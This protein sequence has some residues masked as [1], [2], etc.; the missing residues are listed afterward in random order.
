MRRWKPIPG[1]EGLYEVSNMGEVRSCNRI[2]TNCHGKLIEYQSKR[3]RCHDNTFGYPQV[4][5]CKNGVRKM[6]T[7]HRLVAMTFI[8]NQFNLSEIN[9]RDGDKHN[10]CMWNLEWCTRQENIVHAYKHG[11]KKPPKQKTE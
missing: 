9:H 7:I 8:K 4:C 11:L 3:I 10:N 6:F 2:V 5:L 1:Y